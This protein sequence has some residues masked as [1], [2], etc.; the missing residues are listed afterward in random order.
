MKATTQRV[1]AVIGLVLI[2]AS[3]VL[4]LVSF[5]TGAA[6]ALMSNISLL[7]FG[8]A[9]A[10]LMFLSYKRKQMAADNQPDAKDEE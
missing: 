6:A 5:F 9:V 1:L 7:C 3:I 10:V 8:G 2:V 4:M